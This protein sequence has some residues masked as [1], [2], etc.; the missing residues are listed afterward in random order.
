MPLDTPVQAL[1]AVYLAG[2][3]LPCLVT[4]LT[5]AK[6]MRPS[7]AFKMNLT[8]FQGLSIFLILAVTL[9]GG[10]APILRG[11]SVQ[12]GGFRMGTSFAAG[13]FLAL[14]LVIMLPNA[15]HLFQKALPGWHFPMASFVALLAFV[16]L[17]RIEHFKAIVLSTASGVFLFMGTLHEQKHAPLI[18]NC[19]TAKGFSY[20]LAGLFITAAV[21]LLLGWANHL[22]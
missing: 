20:M 7:F 9:A 15:F 6:E 10:A 17:L 16:F 5:V 13:V 18:I 2:V 22:P 4:V 12:S 11:R 8:I 21:R 3:L 19:C 1:T 14:S